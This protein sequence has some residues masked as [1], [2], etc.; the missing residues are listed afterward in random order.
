MCQQLAQGPW[1]AAAKTLRLWVATMVADVRG[2]SAIEFSFFA[3]LLSLALL[4][5]TDVS[6]YI[7]K[8]MEL[9]NATQMGAQAAFKTCDPSNGY[10]PATTNCPGLNTAVSNAIQSTSLGALVQL[11]SGSP[12]EA[13][14]CL[15]RS[16]ALQYVSSVSQK[17]SDC[18]SVGMAT[19]QPGDYIKISTSYA[20]TPMFSDISIASAFATPITN[21]AMIRLD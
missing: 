4:N 3:G 14:Y 2:T 7:Y 11:Q 20:Y 15:N 12:S 6:I 5:V 8:R 17:L 16:G 13:Y 19:L 18:S 1:V 10:L 21:T 9:E